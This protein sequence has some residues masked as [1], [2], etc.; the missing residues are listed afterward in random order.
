MVKVLLQLYPVLRAEDEDERRRLRPFGRNVERYQETVPARSRWSRR[1]TASGCGA[2]PPS[3]T[4]STPRATRS[5]PSPGMLNAYW[6]A[7]TE[8]IRV[9]PARLH[10]ERPEPDP[11]GGGHRHPRPPDPGPVLRRLLPGLP[12]PLDQHPRPAP[13]H[14]GH[15]V[16]PRRRRRRA[17]PPDLRGAGRHGPRGLDAGEHRPQVRPVAGPLPLRR[18]GRRAGPWQWT[19]EMGAEGEIGDDGSIRRISVVPA[20]Y[21]QPHPPVFVASSASRRPSSTAGA[22]ASSRPTSPASP[23]WPTTGPA[24]VEGARAA[25]RDVALG[26]MQAIVR[27]PQLADTTSRGQEGR[28][29]RRDP[30]GRGVRRGRAH[31]VPPVRPAAGAAAAAGRRRPGRRGERGLPGLAA[32]R[33]APRGRR[34]ARGR[35]AALSTVAAAGFALPA[36]DDGRL[37]VRAPLPPVAQLTGSGPYVVLHPG[38]SVPARAW[39][40]HRCAAAVEALAAAGRRVVVTGGPGEAA[41]TAAVGRDAGTDLGGR[42]SF[43][44]L[45]AVLAGADAVV[46]GNTGPAHLAAAV[47]TPVVSLFAPVVPAA[48]WAPYGV[49]TRAARRP[50]RAVPGQS[51]HGLPGARPPLPGL[52]D[53]GR[54][55]WTLVRPRGSARA[56][57][58][59]RR[60]ERAA[61]MR[62][63][64]WHVHGAWSTAFVQGPHDYLVPVVPGRGPDGRG[65]ARTYDWPD[66]GARGHAGAAGRRAG[67]RG[68]AAAP[69]RPGAGRRAGSA[70][71]RVPAVYVEH[72]CPRGD[73]PHTRH[74]LAG[75]SDLPLV[76]VTHFNALMWDSGR[77]PTTVIEHGVV[78]PGPLW[79]GELARLGVVIN[80]PARRGRL[81]GADLHPAF[82]ADRPGRPVRHAHRPGPGGGRARPAAGRDAQAA[83]P[84]P[85]VRAP[86][87]LDVPRPLPDRGDAPGD[88]GGRAGHDGGGRGGAAG[89]RVPARTGWTC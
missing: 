43:A 81:V 42:T 41:L 74:P 21:T 40:P 17:Q 28:S 10:H 37:R 35:S 26:Q 34:P 16:R 38:A 19:A 14:P 44:E 33:P 31:L 50:A 47:G 46:V 49:P 79:T 87:P 59:C 84:P 6:A 7:M 78:D 73:V 9:G 15:P 64:H 48:R 62:V 24:Y 68:R 63:L 2:W 88:A 57:A 85:G 72:D 8:N 65:R 76:H 29:G 58:S 11:G 22:R 77:A 20:P 60:V 75:R 71:G 18:R 67:R 55:W 54:T 89:A 30:G 3:S 83:G 36:G 80:D 86:V 69:A 70:A 23:A 32:G 12:G 52:G 82:A 27:W 56:D 51:G 4:T 1:P 25:G 45:A 39:S 66:V 61:T 13:R 5:G 53:P